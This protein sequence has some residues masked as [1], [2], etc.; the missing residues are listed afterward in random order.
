MGEETSRVIECRDCGAPLVQGVGIPV[1]D[2]PCPSCGSTSR[3]IKVGLGA[4]MSL[5]SRMTAHKQAED[6]GAAGEAVRISGPGERSASADV[7]SLATAGYQI[8]GPSPRGEEGRLETAQLLVQ[9]LGELGEAWGD[10]EEIDDQDVDC[11]AH[12]DQGMLNVQVTRVSHGD[13]WKALHLAGTAA[14]QSSPDGLADH[15]LQVARAKALLPAV[16]LGSL[17]LAI[18]ARDTPVFAMAGVVNSFRDRHREAAAR[19]GFSSVWVVGPTL[20]LVARLDA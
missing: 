8:A 17:V 16:Q 6:G 10:P 3:L 14:E 4:K 2:G 5:T 18:D 9:K 20:Q 19:L 12:G 1:P 15:L 13:L 11:R 7:S